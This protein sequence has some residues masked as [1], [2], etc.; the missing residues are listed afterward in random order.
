MAS[1][2]RIR[3]IIGTTNMDEMPQLMNDLLGDILGQIGNQSE[4]LAAQLR[5]GLDETD[6]DEL[7]AW[8]ET[9]DEPERVPHHDQPGHDPDDEVHGGNPQDDRTE[10]DR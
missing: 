10:P 3:E 6:F 8:L 2:D 7:M 9:D 4:V 5:E 1:I